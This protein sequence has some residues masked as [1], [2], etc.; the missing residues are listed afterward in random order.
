V[1]NK[2]KRR[3]K[4]GLTL[5][6]LM[7]ALSLSGMVLYAISFAVHLHMR[8]LDIRR[9]NVEESRLA[10]SILQMIANDLRS[11]IPNY[12]VD[13]SGI[14]AMIKNSASATAADV[15]DA[16][17][18]DS[19]SGDS[20]SGDSG[21]GG[22]GGTGTGGTGTGGTGTGGTGTGTGE[23]EVVDETLGDDT[24]GSSNTIDL[25]NA[26]TLPAETGLFGNMS[27]LQVDISRV[28]RPDQLLAYYNNQAAG[29]A[30]E[31]R[32]LPSDIKTVTYYVQIDGGQGVQDDFSKADDPTKSGL[33]R[34]SL[35]RQVTQYA[36]LSG[37]T[38]QL[39]QTG[40]LLGPEV[41]EI[42]FLYF[43]GTELLPE[44]DSI[45]MK[46][47]PLAVQVTLVLRPSRPVQPN[48]EQFIQTEANAITQDGYLIYQ[49]L[50]HLPLGKF[51]EEEELL[52]EDTGL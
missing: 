41:V 45:E 3:P 29:T 33:V 7:L 4:H 38:T 28:P 12:E 27:Q 26:T 1:D 15:A 52:E 48:S 2:L 13:F 39:F 10:R 43:D 5:L 21:S 11:T 50:V 51:V 24:P 46:G 35:D 14:E 19:G 49:M 30:N 25:A 18:G 44:W 34:R 31:L 8:A 32:D 17:G 37:T 9:T 23:E 20:G 42:Q 22:S 16:L 47:L 40:E 36:A 6:E